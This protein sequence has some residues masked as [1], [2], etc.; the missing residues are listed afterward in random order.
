MQWNYDKNHGFS[1]ADKTYIA[2][3]SSADAPTVEDELKD[4]NSLLNY[5]KKMVAI[6]KEHPALQEDG[7]FKVI[8]TGYPA[9]YERTLKDETI[10]V[11]IN[12]S[13]RTYTLTIADKYD[14]IFSNNAEIQQDGLVIRGCGAALLHIQ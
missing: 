8:Q 10:R 12:P 4:E 13:D 9:V 6:R 14:M 1:T 2:C 5:V 11:I 3:D 7:E